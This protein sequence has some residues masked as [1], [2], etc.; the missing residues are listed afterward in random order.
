MT[1]DWREIDWLSLADP[2]EQWRRVLRRA[3]EM[4][5]EQRRTDAEDMDLPMSGNPDANPGMKP[6]VEDTDGPN[7]PDDETPMVG[8]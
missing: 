1:K 6:D 7:S 8:D 4:W 3:R 5:Q 2:V